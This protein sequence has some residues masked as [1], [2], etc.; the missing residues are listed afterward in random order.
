MA[1]TIILTDDTLESTLNSDKPLLLLLTNG[2]GL[3]GDFNTAFRKAATETDILVFAKINPTTNPQ[4]AERFGV[5]SKPV[6]IAW[7]NGAI[8]TRR[9][10]PWG[11]DVPMMVE[12]LQQSLQ[13]AAAGTPSADA[14]DAN[15]A[16]QAVPTTSTTTNQE[17]PTVTLDAPVIVTDETFE[18]EVIN[19]E[20][21][22][23]V[24]F[25]AEWCGPCRMVAPILE[26]IAKEYAG[27]VKVAKVDVDSNPGLAQAFRIMS[28]P[29]LMAVKQKTI[30]YSQPGALPEPAL[31]D[32]TQQ[33]IALEVPPQ[34]EQEASE[35]TSAD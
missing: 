34:E 29:T 15:T 9:S 19:S 23:I 8:L 18:A 5:G 14:N 33:L 4:A 16:A 12:K 32:L 21:P 27:Q 25:W 26:T 24:D 17:K 13:D 2:D 30:V 7:H 22:V 11:T 20:L 1:E 10:R 6:L 28:I 3:R 31:R 35:E